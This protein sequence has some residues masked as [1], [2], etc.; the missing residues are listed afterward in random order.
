MATE[1]LTNVF[2]VFKLQGRVPPGILNRVIT[3]GRVPENGPGRFTVP[4]ALKEIKKAEEEA[5]EKARQNGTSQQTKSPLGKL[6]I[7]GRTFPW[8]R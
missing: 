1:R 3:L 6:R 4:K 2:D 7:N 8:G 5:W